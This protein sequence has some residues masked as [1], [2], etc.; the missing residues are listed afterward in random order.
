MEL[1][2]YQILIPVFCVVMIAKAA[3]H[4]LRHERTLREMI[5]LTIFWGG[6]AAVA[7]FPDA[8]SVVAGVLGIKSNVNAVIFLILGLLSYMCFSL[9]ISVENLE[10]VVTRLT[11]ELA[12]KE[13][14]KE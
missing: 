11:R 10:Q 12:L 6:M 2:L 9:F 7:L 13:K 4:Y 14:D 8:T 3:S 1:A 5:V